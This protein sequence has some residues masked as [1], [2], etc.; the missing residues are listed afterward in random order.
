[1]KGTDFYQYL[2][3]NKTSPI[4]ET[5][6]G[7]VRTMCRLGFP[8]EVYLQNANDA[9]NKLVKKEDKDDDSSR[10]KRKTVG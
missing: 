6:T 5:M 3:K 8:L 4:R 10:W 1:M 9:M 7:G 2:K